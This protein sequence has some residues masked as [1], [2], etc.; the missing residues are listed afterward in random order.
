[1]FYAHLHTVND[2]TYGQDV[3]CGDILGTTG[4][5][6]VTD[7]TCAP[8]LHFEILSN[9]IMGKGSIVH[10]M[11]PGYYVDYK[12]FNDLTDSEKKVQ[13]DE[14]KLGKIK[15]VNGAKKLKYEDMPR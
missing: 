6:G 1:M 15:Q 11:N 12:V 8:H 14:A 10:R 7:G 4:R 3:N 9:Y 2:Y 5:S 13:Q